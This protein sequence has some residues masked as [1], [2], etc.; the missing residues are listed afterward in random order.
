MLNWLKRYVYL[1]LARTPSLRRRGALGLALALGGTF[2]GSGLVHELHAYARS[3]IWLGQFTLQ[4]SAI[5]A[6]T[7]AWFA[8]DHGLKRALQRAEARTR[9]LLRALRVVSAQGAI[10][11]GMLSLQFV[12]S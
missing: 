9:S 4:F 7:L 11:W 10:L 3:L 12:W 1:P 5:G 8:L 2:L 6:A